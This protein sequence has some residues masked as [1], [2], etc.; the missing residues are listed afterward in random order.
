[1]AALSFILMLPVWLKHIA[2]K[3]ELHVTQFQQLMD[4]E[5]KVMENEG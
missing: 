4:K 5:K 3:A 1:M 2:P